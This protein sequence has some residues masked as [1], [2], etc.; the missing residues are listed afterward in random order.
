MTSASS[1]S[2]CSIRM[3][4][5]CIL[6]MAGLREIGAELGVHLSTVSE[7]LQRAGINQAFGRS[8]VP[9]RIH[10]ADPGAA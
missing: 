6:E 2:V 5:E 7:Q 3:V 1:S 9:F 8:S 10:S 4:R